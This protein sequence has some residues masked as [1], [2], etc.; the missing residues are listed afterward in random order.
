MK[1]RQFIINS[2]LTFAA[3]V[4]FSGCKKMKLKKPKIKLLGENLQIL[5]LP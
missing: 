3:T 1:R 5:T 4:L 2:A